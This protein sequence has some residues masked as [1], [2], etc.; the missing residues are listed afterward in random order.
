MLIALGNIGFFF[1][2]QMH[3][4][5]NKGVLQRALCRLPS[6]VGFAKVPAGWNE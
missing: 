4:I 6:E 1:R 2:Y 5:A 3:D